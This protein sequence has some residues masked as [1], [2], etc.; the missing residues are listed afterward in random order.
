MRRRGRYSTRLGDHG[1]VPARLVFVSER[2]FGLVVGA[3]RLMAPTLAGKDVAHTVG[4]CDRKVRANV[5]ARAGM[6]VG[7]L[8]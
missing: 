5:D 4:R 1:W 2:Q 7:L 3:A 8:V 6:A